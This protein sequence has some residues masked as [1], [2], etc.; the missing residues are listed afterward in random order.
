VIASGEDVNILVL[1]TEFIQYR[2]QA[3]KSTP[4]GATAKFAASGKKTSKKDLGLIAMFF[5]FMCT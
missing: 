5:W 1:D 4:I 3:S 2:C